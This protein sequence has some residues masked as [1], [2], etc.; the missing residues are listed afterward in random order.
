MIGVLTMDTSEYVVTLGDAASSYLQHPED[1][2]KG[3]STLE[4]DQILLSFDEQYAADHE[5][6]IWQP[7]R[8]RYCSSIGY[9]KAW[10]AIIA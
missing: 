3:R 4:L 8:R 10:S 1:M 6:F 5:K 7:R 9:D 2:T